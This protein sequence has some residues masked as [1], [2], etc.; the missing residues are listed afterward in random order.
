MRD[1]RS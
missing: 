1:I